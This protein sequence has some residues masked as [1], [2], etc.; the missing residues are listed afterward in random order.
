MDRH[1][2]YI[3]PKWETH[4]AVAIQALYEGRAEPEQQKQALD[5]L[6]NKLCATYDLS[7]RPDSDRDTA[8]A[9]GRRFVGLELVK[10]LKINV[11]ALRQKGKG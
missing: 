8:F 2:P 7:F 3:P 11:A 9:E 6:I 10:L 4:E 5:M 1:A